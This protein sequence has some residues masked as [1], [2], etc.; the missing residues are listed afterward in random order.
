M[1]D[2]T[3]G[4]RWRR[5]G[6][7]IFSLRRQNARCPACTTLANVFGNA[8]ELSSTQALEVGEFIT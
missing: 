5:V 3:A 6:D 7:V 8:V 2:R 1:I 4:S